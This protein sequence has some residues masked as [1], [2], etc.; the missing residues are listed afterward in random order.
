[1]LVHVLGCWTG[2]LGVSPLWWSP[3]YYVLL[4]VTV[5]L[6]R[7]VRVG[8]WVWVTLWRSGVF[9]AVSLGCVVR[10]AVMSV[11]GQLF[12]VISIF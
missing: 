6:S 3:C 9:I 8:K 7:A 11:L 5:Y 2:I 4:R 1:M 10:H 12:L